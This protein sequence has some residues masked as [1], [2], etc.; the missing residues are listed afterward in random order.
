M[1]DYKLQDDAAVADAPEVEAPE[2]E[3]EGDEE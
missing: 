1:V 3:V 2:A